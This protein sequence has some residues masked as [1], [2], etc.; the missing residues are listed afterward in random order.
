MTTKE[1]NLSVQQWSDNLYRFACMNLRD[2]DEANDIVQLSFE[3]L[4]KERDKVPYEK[5][6]SFLFTVA[7]RRCMDVHRQ[8]KIK[9]ENLELVNPTL[10]IYRDQNYEWKEY[11]NKALEILDERSKN[12]ILLKDLEGYRYEEIAE[13]TDLSLEQVK[14]YLHRARKKLKNYLSPY[15]ENT[16]S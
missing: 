12:L 7:Y 8:Q 11:L 2:R 9:T 14:V 13:L 5:S 16:V 1:Y 10:S 3:T 6:K 4:W 15:L